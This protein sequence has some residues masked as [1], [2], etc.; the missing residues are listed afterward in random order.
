MDS[1]P[2][3]A[4]PVFKALLSDPEKCGELEEKG[5]RQ[6]NVFLKTSSQGKN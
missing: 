5:Q 1:N 4:P 2:T 3:S 6:L